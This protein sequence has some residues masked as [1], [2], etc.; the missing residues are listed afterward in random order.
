MSLSTSVAS[1][2]PQ[3][4]QDDNKPLWN[5]VTQ[6]EKIG[7]GGGNF[8][9]KCHFCNNE[10]KGSYTRVKAH[11]L[12]NTGMGI[13][14]CPKVTYQNIAEMQKAI[15]EAELRIKNSKPKKVPLPPSSASLGG[16]TSLTQEA[17]VPKKRKASGGAI[18]KAFNNEAREQLHSEIAR[19]FYSAGLPFHLARNPYY[20][21]SYNYAANNPLSGYLPPGYNLLRTTLLQKEKANIDRLLQPIRS[22]WKAKG[23]SIASDGWSDPQ[24]RPLINFMAMTEGGP[25]F[26]KAVDCSGGI[27]DKFFISNLLKEV[28]NEVGP[29]NVIQVIT[30]NA[31]N[32]KAAG[33]LIEG[34][35]PHIV[36]I[37]C[38]VHTLNLALKN[39][40][41]AKNVEKNEIAYAECGWILDYADEVTI[42]KNFIMNHSMRLAIF[43]EFVSLKLL[44]VAETRFASVIVMMK[45]F[46]LIKGGLQAMVISD[47]WTCYKEDDVG[48]ADY[49]REKL[50][51]E[52]WWGKIDYILSF[53][54]PIYDMLRACDTDKPC[55]HLVY[56]MWD[57]MIEKVKMAIYRY[58]RKRQSESS[59]FY[60]VVHGILVARWNK[61]NTPLHCLAHSL[62]PRY[63]SDVWLSED[64]SR[65]PPHKDLEV[66]R[67]RTRCLKKYFSDPQERSKVQLEYANFSS[68]SGEF[69][70]SDSICDRYTMDP[71]SWWVVHG[72]Y[73]PL[74]QELALKLLVQ[75]SSSSCCERNWSTY[76]FI[77]SLRR[78]KMAPQRAEDLVFIHSNLR[79][80]SRR[81]P[82]YNEGRTK[83]W[84]IAGDAF[85][86]FGDVG[87]LE[88]ANLSLDEPEL[89]A[90]LFTDDGSVNDDEI[91]ETI[92]DEQQ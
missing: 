33:Q 90:V 29:Q 57:T 26:L 4:E 44:S 60:E 18:G 37:P 84:D 8:L 49:V 45:R 72:S 92:D 46:K 43:N 20:V 13:R 10:F 59:S 65:V 86:S 39:I 55:L 79:L 24:R 36:W 63:Y 77:H 64:Q 58:E 83:M 32:C 81:T 47:K 82:Q 48:K 42:I 85:D 16:T 78:N 91:H 69:G 75:P 80:L 50:L 1:C 2:T 76:S 23:V 38:V 34:Q 19:M 17:Y 31:P 53:T 30:D 22:T 11:L 14:I 35:F 6:L 74:L 87:V 70:E 71:K 28:I 67:E 68:N 56:D 7:G 66:S 62:N 89:E 25:M 88:V 15:E 27:K 12:Q 3:F 5:Y 9:F 54:S 61:N 73:G 52:Q 21:S 41:A 51:D 40:C